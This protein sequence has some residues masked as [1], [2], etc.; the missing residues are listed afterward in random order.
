MDDAYAEDRICGAIGW[1]AFDYNTHKDFGSGD[2]ICYHGVA[3]IYRNPK[4]AAFAYASQNSPLPV[5][6]IANPPTLGDY[7][8]CLNKPLYV[9]T[10]C[11][12]V[13]MYK[14][15][16][17]V[18]VFKPDKKDFPHLPHAPIVIDD[19]IGAL[20]NG[21]KFSE[22][23]RGESR[24]CFN[25]LRLSEECHRHWQY[26]DGLWPLSDF[27]GPGFLRQSLRLYPLL[28]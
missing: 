8:E 23:G 13:E 16:K 11:D 12:Y 15:D 1:C 17:F 25:P 5:M 28:V 19:Y 20:M 2:H 9:F 3:D 7:D 4:A 24:S 22:H 21:E 14:N 6:W 27:D 26:S 10:N 18:E